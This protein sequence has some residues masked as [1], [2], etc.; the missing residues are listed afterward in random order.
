[1]LSAVCIASSALLLVLTPTKAEVLQEMGKVLDREASGLDSSSLVG[2]WMLRYIMKS[3]RGVVALYPTHNLYF[4]LLNGFMVTCIFG[5]FGTMASVYDEWFTDDV[6]AQLNV[7]FGACMA[8][9]GITCNPI[10][11]MLMDRIGFLRTYMVCVCVFVFVT[12]TTPIRSVQAQQLCIVGLSLLL[13]TYQT[14]AM[15]YCILFAPPEMFGSML[16]GFITALGVIV[17]VCSSLN[18]ALVPLEY[19]PI[20]NAAFAGLATLCGLRL[21]SKFLQAHGIPHV[22]PKDQYDFPVTEDASPTGTF[23]ISL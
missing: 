19:E 5:F 4:I 8:L 18:S 11:G 15:K 16:G 21:L 12:I 22:P 6:A 13:A 9:I 14:V 23:R 10:V 7:F 1:M 20:K 3:F 2:Y 17:M